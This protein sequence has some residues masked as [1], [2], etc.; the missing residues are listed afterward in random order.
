[1][2]RCRGINRGA[3][4]RV[5]R[6]YGQVP[7]QEEMRL[8]AEAFLVVVGGVEHLPRQVGPLASDSFRTELPHRQ[9]EFLKG[10]RAAGANA[11]RDKCV[12]RE[13]ESREKIIFSVT[14]TISIS[15]PPL[16]P[17]SLY[18]SSALYGPRLPGLVR[19]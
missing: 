4:R 18:I 10:Q 8:H 13:E 14:P 2:E 16:S 6:L 19:S 5:R 9:R 7:Q 3:M 17:C 1:M 12:N 15:A 11:L